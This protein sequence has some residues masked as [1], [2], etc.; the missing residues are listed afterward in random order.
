MTLYMPPLQ[1]KKRV[2]SRY[3]PD[4][5]RV[6]S[7]DAERSR[8]RYAGIPDY[9][10]PSPERFKKGI[11]LP[12]IY[13]RDTQVLPKA[14][15]DFR[16]HNPHPRSCGFLR[17]DVRLLN[18]PICSVYTSHTH[19]EQN[20]WWPSRTSDEPL[21]VP[22][23]TKDTIY[24]SDYM[25]EHKEPL[26]RTTRH[27]SNTKREPALGPVP[28][29]FLTKRD[30]TQR[31]FQEKKSYEH[32]YN[33]RKD[34]NYPI[35]GKRLGSFVWDEMSPELA[36]RFVDQHTN[37]LEA[38]EKFEA[39]QSQKAHPPTP[40][41]SNQQEKVSETSSNNNVKTVTFKEPSD[42]SKQN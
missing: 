14:L 25:K 34:P 28:V 32:D 18:E 5:F 40:P 33:S 35:R 24:R 42:S 27:E 41:S 11:S 1:R 21:Q 29:N 3:N 39:C 37:L 31:I 26:H 23:K 4:S 19:D 22:P 38:K 20:M 2:P 7:N 17:H 9:R 30:G 10:P 8:E 15:P 36:Q 12:N 6:I 16:V 13:S